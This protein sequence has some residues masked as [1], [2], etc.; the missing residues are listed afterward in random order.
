MNAISR[1]IR[2]AQ[3]ITAELNTGYHEEEEVWSIFSRLI[4][5]GVDETFGLL[6]PFHPDFGKI[7]GWADGCSSTLTAS[8]WTMGESPSAMMF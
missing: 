8:S 3:R 4:G 5:T 2:E 7:S 1:L 6:P